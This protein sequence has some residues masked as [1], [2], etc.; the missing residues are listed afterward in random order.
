METQDFAQLWG[1]VR[2]YESTI[3]ESQDKRLTKTRQE[4][5][6]YTIQKVEQAELSYAMTAAL[7]EGIYEKVQ[8]LFL[9]GNKKIH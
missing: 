5:E 3:K 6:Q 4:N 7:S 1:E 8:D 2:E 9:R